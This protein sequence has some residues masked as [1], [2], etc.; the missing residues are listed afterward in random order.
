M[1]ESL[2]KVATVGR[3]GWAFA[4]DMG[5]AV[6]FLITWLQPYAFDEFMVHKLTFMMLIQFLVVH[7]TGFFSAISSQ[8]HSALFRLSMAAGLL[9]IYSLFAWG[10]SALYGGPWPFYAFMLV[11]LPRLPEILFNPPNDRDQSW[12]IG[13]WAGM[14]LLYLSGAFATLLFFVPPLGVTEEVIAHQ[15]FGIGGAWPEEPYRVLAFGAYYFAGQAFLFLFI[16]LLARRS[17]HRK[18]G[19]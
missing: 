12:A 2:E 10:F 5:L 4:W 3:L 6:L 19:G 17:A 14:V 18:A 1:Q 9:A 13:A 15:D 7:A 11:V 16:E 8:A